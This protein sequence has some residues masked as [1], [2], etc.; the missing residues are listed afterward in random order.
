MPASGTPGNITAGAGWLYMAPLGT[1]E[2]ATGIAALAA[3]WICLGYTDGG[4][5]IN[6]KLTVESTFVD[7]ETDPVLTQ[8]T[9]ADWTLKVTLAEAK[10]QNLALAFG[11]GV[12]T[13]ADGTVLEPTDGPSMV[14]CMLIHD[15]LATP[16]TGNVRWLVRNAFPGGDL[17]LKF[18]KAPAATQIP[19]EFTLA[20]SSSGGKVV[21]VFPTSGGLVA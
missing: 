4:I 15:S 2:P 18:A 16:A 21:K 6:R 19:L 20:K 1:T 5:E 9:K 14:G 7:Q 17:A 12:T 11:G 10:R 3:D 8:A 13:T